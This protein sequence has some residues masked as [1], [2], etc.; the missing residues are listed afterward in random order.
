MCKTMARHGRGTMVYYTSFIE[1]ADKVKSYEI[2]YS[3]AA[4]Y[5]FLSLGDTNDK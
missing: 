4:D 1:A 2:A 3:P 5:Q